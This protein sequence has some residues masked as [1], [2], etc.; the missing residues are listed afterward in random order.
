MASKNSSLLDGE[1]FLLDENHL[2]VHDFK[3]DLKDS[4]PGLENGYF[5]VG[6]ESFSVSLNYNDS[7]LEFYNETSRQELF[8]EANKTGKYL[9]YP[10]Y[11]EEDEPMPTFEAGPLIR[12]DIILE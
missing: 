2:L 9:K 8:H 6:F 5:I 1:V 11:A 3:N 10:D 7:S 4:Y 12:N